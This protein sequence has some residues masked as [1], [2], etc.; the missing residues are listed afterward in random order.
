[1]LC[2]IGYI[3]F[4]DSFIY[5]KDIIG[6]IIFVSGG[7]EESRNG[8]LNVMIFPFSHNLQILNHN[9]RI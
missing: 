1:M 5:P 3:M 9:S 2:N 8:A 6:R 4:N 7:S